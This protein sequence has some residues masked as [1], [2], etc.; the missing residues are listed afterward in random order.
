MLLSALGGGV[1]LRDDPDDSAYASKTANQIIASEF[2][3]RSNYLALDSDLTAVLPNNP[4]TVFSPAY[5][6][7]N[8]E[9]ILHDLC[10]NLGDYTWGVWDH[11]THDDTAGLPTW[12]LEA[13]QRDTT[14][15]H[16]TAYL[17]DILSWRVAPS[18]QRAYN[19]VQVTYT[20]ASTGPAQVTVADTR[21]AGSGAQNQAPF[22]R[23][24]LRLSERQ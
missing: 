23:R 18:A 12:R 21:L 20:D 13:H 10:G 7:Y 19:V 6:G 5:D 3:K 2:S 15:T 16:Y 14:T 17:Q 9:E 1:A 8:L 4:A 11:P 24:K 22:R